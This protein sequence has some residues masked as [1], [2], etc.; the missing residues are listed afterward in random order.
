MNVSNI[1]WRK[2]VFLY[3]VALHLFNDVEELAA[4]LYIVVGVQHV[5]SR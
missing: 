2:G 5:M 4:M 1:K 3:V